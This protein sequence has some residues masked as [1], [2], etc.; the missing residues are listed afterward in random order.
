LRNLKMRSK[1]SQ[2]K[3]VNRI[4]CMLRSRHAINN[5]QNPR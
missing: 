4:A 1:I 5:M 2:I 3:F